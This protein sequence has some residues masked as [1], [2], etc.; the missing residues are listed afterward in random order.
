MLAFLLS[1]LA[2][3]SLL[4][5]Y[6]F[7]GFERQQSI[8]YPFLILLVFSV[9]DLAFAWLPSLRLRILSAIAV[10]ALIAA[11]FVF[12]WAHMLRFSEELFSGG[13]RAFRSELPDVHA[14]YVD[15]FSLVAYYTHTHE[16][17][18]RFKEH[19]RVPERVD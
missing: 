11:H 4:R 13:Y 10:A 9:C 7:G 5:R 15:Q 2:I 3:L 18:W 1:Q 16:W 19:F 12:S 14:I 17:N 8:I 6:P